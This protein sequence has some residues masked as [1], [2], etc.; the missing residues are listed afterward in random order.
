MDRKTK[1]SI[2]RLME[3]QIYAQV[4]EEISKGEKREGL[5]ARLKEDG[6][7]SDEEFNEA[8]VKL[9]KRN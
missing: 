7:I 8:R 5:W 4:Y 2:N 1:A 3:E 6:H 9:L